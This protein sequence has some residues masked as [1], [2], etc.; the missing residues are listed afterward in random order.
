M[1]KARFS[2][3][4]ESRE[5]WD[6]FP[7]TGVCGRRGQSAL[8][9][10]VARAIHRWHV[11]VWIRMGVVDP[12]DLSVFSVPSCSHGGLTRAIWY[13]CAS[14][15]P[16]GTTEFG[17]HLH[18]RPVPHVNPMVPG[19]EP[20]FQSAYMPIP[21]HMLADDATRSSWFSANDSFP[22]LPSLSDRIFC[23]QH[24]APPPACKT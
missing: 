4:S 24:S 7:E 17:R 6:L 20:G 10:W 14:L 13:A 21:A 2:S 22:L 3:V 23:F 15:D 19:P 5:R 16:F 1:A 18:I 12:I 11:I 8:L 9:E